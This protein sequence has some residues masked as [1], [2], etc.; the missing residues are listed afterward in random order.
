MASMLTDSLAEQTESAISPSIAALTDKLPPLIDHILA[1][2]DVTPVASETSI[3][4][5]GVLKRNPSDDERDAEHGRGNVC[6]VHT[7]GDAPLFKPVQQ[8]PNYISKR[9]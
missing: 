7:G 6:S 8:S 5:G 3:R 2:H 4:D 9:Q 1:A